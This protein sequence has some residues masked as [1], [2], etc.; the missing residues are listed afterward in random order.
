MIEDKKVKLIVF[1]MSGWRNQESQSSRRFR[2]G[3]CGEYVSSDRGYHTDNVA[4]P[5]YIFLCHHC[6]RPTYFDNDEPE[7]QVP[8][9]LYGAEVLDIS[10]PQVGDLY[11]EARRCIASRSYTSSVLACRKLLMHI[12]VDQGAAPGERFVKYVEY[13]SDH[14]YVPPGAKG[15]VDHIRQKGN[16]ANHEIVIMTEDEAKDLIKFSEMLLKMIYEF[17]ASV[18]RKSEKTGPPL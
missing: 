14:H 3:H 13:L 8:G 10:D 17:P 7:T 1:G 9:A 2:C 12:A 5:A 18:A 6:G 16:E 11:N 15:W 4:P